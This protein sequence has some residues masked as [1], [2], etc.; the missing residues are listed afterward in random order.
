MAEAKA[1][2]PEK[3]TAGVTW[4][5]KKTISDGVPAVQYDAPQIHTS[6]LGQGGVCR[7]TW[8]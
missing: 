3:L 8:H 2:E 6:Q 1:Y 4:K 7:I 5:W